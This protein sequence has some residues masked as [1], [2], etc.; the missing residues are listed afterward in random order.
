M[1]IAATLMIF[2]SSYY[3]NSLSIK[4]FIQKST[5]FFIK[6]YIDR[7]PLTIF[8]Y[9]IINSDKKSFNSLPIEILEK[10]CLFALDFEELGCGPITKTTLNEKQTMYYSLFFTS[11]KTRQALISYIYQSEVFPDINKLHPSEQYHYHPTN[12]VKYLMVYYIDENLRKIKLPKTNTFSPAYLYCGIDDDESNLSFMQ[13]VEILKKQILTCIH[14]IDRE[15]I[16][17]YAHSYSIPW[18]GYSIDDPDC[19][20][21]SCYIPIK[22][23][24]V[25]QQKAIHDTCQQLI[26]YLIKLTCKKYPL[27]EKDILIKNLVHVYKEY[28][29]D[30]KYEP[31]TQ[32]LESSIYTISRTDNLFNTQYLSKWSNP[33][34]KDHL[35]IDNEMQ[36]SLDTLLQN[37]ITLVKT[38]YNFQ[39]N[40]ENI[41]FSNSITA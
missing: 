40:K 1:F 24:P 11:K 7:K 25:S 13:I 37:H 10:I 3:S 31:I 33:Q 16:I 28:I 9:K 20:Y 36:N 8:G 29:N 23:D 26:N 14:F 22:T 17:T 12:I 18:N 39:L 30:Q 5:N 34:H 6:E 32:A 19:E 2:I 41:I 38:K 27:L 15:K 35:Q 21:E 4:N